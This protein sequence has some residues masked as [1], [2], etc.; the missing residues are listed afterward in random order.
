[1]ET[2]QFH[3]TYIRIVLAWVAAIR[4][5]VVHAAGEGRNASVALQ[6]K[7]FMPIGWVAGLSFRLGISPGQGRHART[8]H[9][10]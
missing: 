7:E 6:A 8:Y 1:M 2:K 3:K 10:Q 4:G 5:P 9:N